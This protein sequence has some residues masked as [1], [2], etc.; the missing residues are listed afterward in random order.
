MTCKYIG[1]SE[2]LEGTQY[3][4]FGRES[5]SGYTSLTNYKIHGGTDR[6]RRNNE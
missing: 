6:Q 1:W 5:F 2:A 3:N 4:N